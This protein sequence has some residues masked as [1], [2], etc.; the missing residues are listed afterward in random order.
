MKM[1]IIQRPA[2]DR[3][4]NDG[5]PLL[6]GVSAKAA[7]V[8]MFLARRLLHRQKALTTNLQIPSAPPRVPASFI[9]GNV[10]PVQPSSS[11]QCLQR[12][13]VPSLRPLPALLASASHS[14]GI[15]AP[16]R[17]QPACKA[18]HLGHFPLVYCERGL[19]WQSRIVRRGC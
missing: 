19:H 17:V 3:R 9:P 5:A 18:S 4:F 1:A 7:G 13:S 11:G 12:T 6:R 16:V 8:S 10:G 15:Y 14:S 2:G